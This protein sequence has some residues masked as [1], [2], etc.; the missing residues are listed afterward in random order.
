[1]T[2]LCEKYRASC[3][4][5][6]KGQD[7]AVAMIKAFIRTFPSGKKAVL[8][9]GPAG[10]GKTSLAYVLT[11]ELGSEILELNSSDLRNRDQLE[12]ILKPASETRSLSGKSKIILVDEVDG[13][14]ASDRGGLPE[15]LSLIEKTSFP[16]IMTA[17]NI[18]GQKFNLLRKKAE[19]IQLRALD[20]RTIFKI[21]K[22]IA[23]KEK[24]PVSQE[25]LTSISIKCKG[26]VR[27]ALNDLQT[28][29]EINKPE[30]ISERDKEEDIF[31]ILR[32]IF[33]NLPSNRTLQLY[34]TLNMPLDEIMLWLEENIPWEYK[35]LELYKAFEC[36]SKADVFRGRIHRQQHW[37]FLVYQN[38]LLSAGVSSAKS[39]P[40]TGF[41]AYKRPGRILK[42]WLANQRNEKRKSIARK[43]AKFCHISNLRAISEFYL[44]KQILVN[45]PEVYKNLK[46]TDDEVEFL[47]KPI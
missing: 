32:V 15:L 13:I 46:L 4:L 33:K 34:D 38:I 7:G 35:G 11:H 23:E 21:L 10:T 19:I 29:F 28:V 8:L 44:V 26:D 5:D 31:N 45:K 30:E 42:I 6:L 3:F 40:K 36:I 1:M 14:S 22:E 43:Y 24:I 16:I 37:R 47:E 27:A 41:T 25:I 2:T 17:N 20:Y 18:W 12:K 9:H 39:Q